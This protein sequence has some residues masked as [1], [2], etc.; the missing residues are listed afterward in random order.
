MAV[1]GEQDRWQPDVL[2]RSGSDRTIVVGS[3][4]DVF[5]CGLASVHHSGIF[6]RACD[7]VP[8]AWPQV[9][10]ETM[11]TPGYVLARRAALW[12][13][14]AE[15]TQAVRPFLK[16]AALVARCLV[17]VPL[18]GRTPLFTGGK[19]FSALM[20]KLRTL[21]SP[22]SGSQSRR[23]SARVEWPPLQP[24]KSALVCAI[25]LLTDLH[26]ERS[27]MI[28]PDLRHAWHLWR[29]EFVLVTPQ[30]VEAEEQLVLGE[31]SD[32]CSARWSH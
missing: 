9:S 11:V 22:G 6:K 28:P 31:V 8:M 32:G 24:A 15:V 5:R 4:S 21:R 25:R 2:I 17:D 3:A 7:V 1:R 26:N 29:H 13:L 18:G 23:A 19:G 10:A 20:N 12:P 16:L 30:G 27:S 14:H